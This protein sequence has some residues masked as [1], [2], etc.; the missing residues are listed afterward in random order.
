MGPFHNS[1]A[2]SLSSATSSGLSQLQ[3]ERS[4]NPWEGGNEINI[5]NSNL[6]FLSNHS[7]FGGDQHDSA[8]L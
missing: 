6:K 8:T 7:D 5:V 2:A 4:S 3:P 1:A